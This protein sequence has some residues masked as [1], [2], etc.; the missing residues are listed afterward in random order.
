VTAMPGFAFQA[1]DTPLLVSVPHDGREIPEAQRSR[2]TPA[3]LDIPDT[4]WHVAALYDFV[5]GLGASVMVAHGSR[6]VVDLNRSADD[7]ELYPGQ[8]AT[9]LCPEQTFAGE[10]IYRAGDGVPAGEQAERVASWWQPYHDCLRHTLDGLRERHGY[11]LL[12]D[13]HSI[14]G[15]VPRLFEGELPT[16]NIG[17]FDGRSCD[18][19]VAAAVAGVAAD[20]PFDSVV[21]GRFRGG[22]I[23]RHYGAPHQQVHAI[24]LEIAQRAYMDEGT[25][26]YDARKA[27]TLRQ[28]L[29]RMLSAYL[30]SAARRFGS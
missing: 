9:G 7:G 23:T 15:R 20:S 22:Y 13:A 11:A 2:M 19:V 6:Y 8:V 10:R 1:G 18:G 12:W 21:N 16:L 30:E 4:D 26:L 5:H 14:P 3:G 29:R 24:Q 28:T 25:R 17:T 27:D